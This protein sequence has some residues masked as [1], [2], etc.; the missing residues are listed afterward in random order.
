[1]R[2]Y[3]PTH[4]ETMGH[5]EGIDFSV[6]RRASRHW[7]LHAC[8]KCVAKENTKQDVIDQFKMLVDGGLI[9]D[10]RDLLSAAETQR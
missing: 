5:Y 10:L 1:M 3:D 4:G 8:G 9:H 2:N 7:R 6:E